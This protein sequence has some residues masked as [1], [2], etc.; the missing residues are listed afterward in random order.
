MNDLLIKKD[1]YR[2]WFEFYKIALNSNLLTIKQ[3]LDKSRNFYDPWGDVRNIKFDDWWK[4]HQDL[5]TEKV[6]VSILRTGEQRQSAD[7]L[8]I[9]VPLNQATSSLLKEIKVLLDANQRSALNQKNKKKVTTSFQLSP[10]A[11]LKLDTARGMLN[12]YRDVY[13]KDTSLRG[14]KLL[15]ATHAFYLGR[16]KNKK[17]PSPI[18]YRHEDEINRVLR[19]LRRWIENADQIL[20]NVSKGEF[21]GKY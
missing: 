2:I 17:I 9:E 10:G 5:F 14:K 20:I 19:N 3:N 11:E 15:A 6:C 8:I 13:L 4:S 16:A 18:T 1:T 7:S 12:V 21:P